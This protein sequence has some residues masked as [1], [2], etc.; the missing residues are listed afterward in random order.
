MRAAARKDRKAI[1]SLLWLLTG[2]AVF[3]SFGF[4]R[5]NGTDLWWH[6]ATG[7]WISQHRSFPAQDPFSFTAHSKWV[8]DSWLS[9]VVLYQWSQ[10][11][12][13]YSLV[14][15][16]WILIVAIFLLLA[17]VCRRVSHE[18]VAGFFAAIFA[19]TV[20]QPFLDIRPHLF[21][22][23]CLVLLFLIVL[24]AKRSSRSRFVLLFA[25]FLLWANLHAGVVLG[26]LL[27][28]V[29][30]ARDYF[31]AAKRKAAIALTAGAWLITLANPNGTGV[32]R[33]SL[34]YA[35]RFDDPFRARIAEWQAPFVPGG[36]FSPLYPVALFL[37]AAAAVLLL[38]RKSR[39]RFIPLIGIG[40][41]TLLLSLQSRRLIPAFAICIAPALAAAVAPFSR[42]W[43]KQLPAFALPVVLA[44]IAAFV[45]WRY[46]LQPRVFHH[47]TTEYTFPA[48][49][50]NFIE[51]ND[52]S[53][54]I[55]AYY[56]WGGYLHWRI[57]GQMKVFIDARASAVF[58]RATFRDYVKIF[59]E[60]PGWEAIIQRTPVEYLLWP[61]EKESLYRALLRSNQW[62]FVY[63]DAISVLLVR[64]ETNLPPLRDT[65]NSPYRNLAL[66]QS[67][68]ERWAWLE[69]ESFLGRALKEM[70]WLEPACSRLA[71]VKIKQGKMEES[72][73]VFRRCDA[74]F[75]DRDRRKRVEEMLNP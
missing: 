46:P 30:L 17:K 68:M 39:K 51:T 34:V 69:A 40:V 5:L 52:L 19:A 64:A 58:E 36:V 47:L 1:G 53:G 21:S 44:G 13:L 63:R 10:L 73:R 41:F 11:F 26:V 55:F 59:S 70:P 61:I 71:F 28:P 14:Y 6:L 33:Q 48:E 8:I 24:D 42:K 60:E 15:W 29:L 65:P 22:L 32:Y 74:I 23:L 18:Q 27:L 38:G 16:K 43:V 20:A 45:L 67:A 31:H 62:R 72:E 12:G 37:F 66:G 56:N 2:V 7:R 57:P 25:L 4:A 75:P 35:L 50:V 49:T 3:W 9:D 54:N